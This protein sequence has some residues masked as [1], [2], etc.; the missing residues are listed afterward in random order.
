MKK[1]Q[2]T[3][4]PTSTKGRSDGLLHLFLLSAFCVSNN[5]KNYRD[6]INLQ[7]LTLGSWGS[8]DFEPSSQKGLLL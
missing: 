3:N 2:P 6:I 1:D 4:K 8:W 5:A 7:V